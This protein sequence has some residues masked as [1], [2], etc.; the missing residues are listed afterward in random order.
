M[1]EGPEVRCIADQLR[2]LVGCTIQQITMAG[3]ARTEIQH[4]LTVPDTITA[5]MSYGKKLLIY[6]QQQL[7]IVS[8]GMTGRF[9]IITDKVYPKHSKVF[10]YLNNDSTLVFEDSRGFGKVSLY[11]TTITPAQLDLGPDVLALALTQSFTCQLLYQQLMK[12]K[13]M[14]IVSA[15]LEQNLLTGIGNYLRSEILYYA[16]IHPYRKID[17]LNNE[18]WLRLHKSICDVITAAYSCNGLTIQ[19]YISP[20]GKFGVYQCAVY[21]K[22][23]DP[24]GNQVVQEKHVGRSI[25]YVPR[26]QVL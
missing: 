4:T 9:V 15:L 17:S 24:Y 26:F 5:I 6:T 23:L 11:A 1:P 22:Q 3:N 2:C 21:Q 14:K 25:F 8:L 10:W 7:F 19:D 18:E 12:K 20:D 16:A 13:S